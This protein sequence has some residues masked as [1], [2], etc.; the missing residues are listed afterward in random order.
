MVLL[1]RCVITI[2]VWTGNVPY[3]LMCLKSGPQLVALFGEV[4]GPSWGTD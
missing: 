4:V 3:W 2:K 1:A